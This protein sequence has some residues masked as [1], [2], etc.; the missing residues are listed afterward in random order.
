MVIL[1]GDSMPPRLLAVLFLIVF[2]NLVGF[3]I[4]I[5][6][7]PVYARQHG[8]SGATIGAIVA[9]YALTQFVF[10]PI[11]GRL[12]DRVGRRP[13]LLICLAGAAGG[14]LLFAASSTVGLLVV[15]RATAGVFAA[16]IGTAQAAIADVSSPDERIR[17]MG[18]IGA[19]YGLGFVF[20]PPIG[21]TLAAMSVARGF[22][23]STGPGV[24]AAAFA[25][26]ALLLAFIALP[27]TR[28]ERPATAAR[29]PPQ[30]QT[31]FW[32]E[33]VN[34]AALR[35][36]FFSFAA[37]VLALTALETVV[38]VYARE[39]LRMTLHEVGL[40]FGFLGAVM[41]L[42]QIKA[43]AP[44]AR[45]IGERRALLCAFALLAI[46]VAAIPA[47]RHRAFLYLIAAA[48][49]VGQGIALPSVQSLVSRSS[50]ANEQGIF[51]GLLAAT[52]SISQ[53]IGA[54]GAGVLYGA[55][56]TAMP[57]AAAALVLLLAAGA[58][59][60]IDETFSDP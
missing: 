54:L 42:V 56:G 38:P 5:P 45:A 57:F 13:V 43:V 22:G 55:V 33:V 49:A 36:H 53:V 35:I 10:S 8:A 37:L 34:S 2:V 32:R 12:S 20:G 47:A 60:L 16:T 1:R 52:G 21:G 18:V 6:L 29:R 11:W 25:L 48:V 15:A 59:F 31:T 44:I 50:P 30:F 28:S 19:A 46:A 7:L 4:V 24:F 3:G 51:L 41:A 40:V 9:V 58:Y 27:E 23:A 14:H 39:Q 26:F 17:G